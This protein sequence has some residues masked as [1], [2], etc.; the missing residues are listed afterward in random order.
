MP[1]MTIIVITG[2]LVAADEKKFVNNFKGYPY[3]ALLNIKH[4]IDLL[5]FFKIKS[6]LIISNLITYN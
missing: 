1:R 6:L 4:F 3:F 5:V 2:N